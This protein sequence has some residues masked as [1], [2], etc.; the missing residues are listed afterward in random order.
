MK[1]IGTYRQ[2]AAEYVALIEKIEFLVAS[3]CNIASV[4]SAVASTG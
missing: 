4:R 3:S 1:H 2:N